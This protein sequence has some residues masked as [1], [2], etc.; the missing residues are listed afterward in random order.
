MTQDEEML[1]IRN[2][3]NSLARNDKAGILAIVADN[4]KYYFAN[5]HDLNF[6]LSP[7]K[8]VFNLGDS[9]IV[10]SIESNPATKF[11]YETYARKEAERE[12][13]IWDYA[14]RKLTITPEQHPRNYWQSIVDA[15]N[16]SFYFNEMQLLQLRN[17]Y[18]TTT[19]NHLENLKNR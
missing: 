7:K 1:A 3:V 5:M 15:A 13:Y 19:A 16:R 17:W 18:D 12:Y 9:A 14:Q 11:D 10:D 4:P 6:L 2:L 8:D